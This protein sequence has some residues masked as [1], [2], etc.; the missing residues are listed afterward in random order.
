M[1]TRATRLLWLVAVA[2]GL[3]VASVRP[4]AAQGQAA[5]AASASEAPTCLPR[6]EVRRMQVVDDRNVLFVMRD[7]RTFRN[8]LARQCPGL[9]RDSQVSLTAADRQV[10]GGSNFQVLLRVGSGSNS[11]SVMVPGGSTMSVPRPSF[12]PGPTCVLGTFAPI[13]DAEVEALLESTRRARANRRERNQEESAT[14]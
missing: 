6:P 1:S 9:R 11:E 5:P 7:K 2:G 8:T 14:Q 12:V 10:C 13:S 4:A 3:V